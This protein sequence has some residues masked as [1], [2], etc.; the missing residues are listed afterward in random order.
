MKKRLFDVWHIV[1]NISIIHSMWKRKG[2]TLIEIIIVVGIISII[3][4][5][6][7]RIYSNTVAQRQLDKEVD[8]LMNILQTAKSR[9]VARDISP[10]TPLPGCTNFEGYTVLLRPNGTYEDG[11]ICDA[12]STAINTYA[13]DNVDFNGLTVN[14]RINFMYPYGSLDTTTRVIQIRSDRIDRCMNIT[15]PQLGPLNKSEMF[16]C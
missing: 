13:L 15:I 7:M 2:F 9:S 5:G 3:I 10:L 16:S 12:N 14:L 8:G 11:I 6:S 4:G 1:Q